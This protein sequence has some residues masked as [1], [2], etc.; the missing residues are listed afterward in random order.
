M[1][2]AVPGEA[3]ETTAATPLSVVRPEPL[4]TAGAE[5]APN[6]EPA[7]TIPPSTFPVTMSAL[8][9]SG[10]VA[11]EGIP[12][13]PALPTS[14]TLLKFTKLPKSVDDLGTEAQ[15]STSQI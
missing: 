13:K 6:P 2:T 5:A 9:L 10:W 1:V 12:F 4:R 3:I 14:V 7:L 15:P 8:P 11:V